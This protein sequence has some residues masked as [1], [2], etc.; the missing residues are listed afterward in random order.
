MCDPTIDKQSNKD[1]TAANFKWQC[2]N[3]NIRCALAYLH[4]RLN[5][6][7]KFAWESGKH[8]PE[9]ILEQLSQAEIQYLKAYLENLQNYNQAVSDK[10]ASSVLPDDENNVNAGVGSFDPT[11]IDLTVDFNPPKDLFIE[12]RVNKDYGT[13][14]LPESGEVHLLKNS[15][16]LLRRTEVDH[17]IKR[18][19]MTEVI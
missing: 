15:T 8:L 17:L 19:I 11:S 16:H 6:I 13:V 10:L 3:R 12:V 4:T 1:V 7:E 5:K 18:G 2:M 9:H 14:I